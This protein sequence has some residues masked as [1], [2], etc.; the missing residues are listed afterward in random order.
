[1]IYDDFKKNYIALYHD[2][3]GVPF[4]KMLP[5]C[6]SPDRLDELVSDLVSESPAFIVGE[7]SPQFRRCGVDNRVMLKDRFNKRNRNT[8]YINT[9]DE[10]YS[11]DHLYYQDDKY[12]GFSDY[13]I[14]GEEFSETGF[15]PYAVAIH[16]VYFDDKNNLRIHHFVSDSNNDISDPAGKFYEALEK[17]VEWNKEKQLRTEGMKQFEEMYR[18]QTY[19]GLGVVKKLSIMHHLEIVG[20]F[21][22]GVE[23]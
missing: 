10:F 16:I 5:I 9:I 2:K 22:N 4:S 6:L 13:S 8:D 15:A 12:I 14:V 3:Y 23:K 21:L 17:L 7:D 20:N 11:N 19:S 1:M 18:T